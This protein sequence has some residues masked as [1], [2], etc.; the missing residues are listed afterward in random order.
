MSFRRENSEDLEREAAI[1]DWV[2]KRKR[3]QWRKLGN[4]GKY[5]IDAC[6]H[7]AEQMFAWVEVKAHGGSFCGMNVPKYIEGCNLS[8]WTEKPFYFIFSREDKI[9]VINVWE[10]GM[11]TISPVLQVTGGTPPGRDPLPDDIEPMMMFNDNHVKAW[12]DYK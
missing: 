4:G 12:I 6:F 7:Q 10:H 2:G 5:R 9:G 8:S 11:P 3:W 1:L